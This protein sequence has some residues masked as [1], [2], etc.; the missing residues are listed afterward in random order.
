MSPSPF[1][2][3]CA[4]HTLETILELTLTPPSLT[5]LMWFSEVHP[6]EYHVI[7]EAHLEE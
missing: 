4:A 7:S 6:E 3:H 1:R 2:S 5:H